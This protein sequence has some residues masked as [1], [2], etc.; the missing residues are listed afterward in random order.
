LLKQLT[1]TLTVPDILKLA[2]RCFSVDPASALRFNSAD[3]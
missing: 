2:C 3:R 1:K